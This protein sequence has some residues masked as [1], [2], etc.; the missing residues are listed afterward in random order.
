MR[1]AGRLDEALHGCVTAHIELPRR[2]QGRC[3]TSRASLPPR[4]LGRADEAVEDTSSA[5]VTVDRSHRQ[6]GA[7][8]TAGR[9]TRPLP[10]CEER[11]RSTDLG[12]VY[13]RLADIA[14]QRGDE[15]AAT[16][17]SDK[18][19]PGTSG[20][21][22]TIR[23]T[24][25]DGKTWRACGRVSAITRC[26]ERPA[27][28][29]QID[30]TDRFEGIPTRSFRG[31]GWC[32]LK[33]SRSDAKTAPHD[34]AKHETAGERALTANGPAPRALHRA[35]LQSSVRTAITRADA[36]LAAEHRNWR[37]GP[38]GV[39]RAANWVKRL[40]DDGILAAARSSSCF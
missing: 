37:C 8:L 22:T 4:D 23:S 16:K 38:I 29:L 27:N 3:E 28:D 7:V 26:G 11:Y 9:L 35:A 18:R 12:F 13:E 24:A 39:S 1:L 17:E 40:A 31:H 15:A 25:V 20:G 14:R 19:Q 5:S 6:P 30:R 34:Q 2:W 36:V 33:S 21:R 32:G 10:R